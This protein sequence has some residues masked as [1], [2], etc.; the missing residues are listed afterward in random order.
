M[1]YILIWLEG[2]VITLAFAVVVVAAAYILRALL[3]L[4]DKYFDIF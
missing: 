3:D 1:G 4:L 2:V